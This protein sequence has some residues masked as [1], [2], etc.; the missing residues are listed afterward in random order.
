MYSVVPPSGT[1]TGAAERPARDLTA[2]IA[3]PTIEAGA[4][5]E[6]AVALA[7]MLVGAGHRA[8]V[9]SGG[10]RLESRLAEAGVDLVRLDMASRSPLALARN[11]ARLRDLVRRRQCDVVHAHGRAAAWSALTAARTA[12]VPFLTTWYKGFREQNALKRV[13]NGVMARGARV[14]TPSDQLAELIVARHH[15]AWERIAVI[16]A[17]IDA[18]QFD[19][20]ALTVERINA[21]RR[22]WGVKADTKV[23]LVPGRMLR[24]KG[25]HVA[26][27][28]ARRLKDMG[29]KNFLFVFAGEDQGRSRYSGELWDLVLATGTADVIR[30]GWQAADVVAAYGAATAV[31]SAAIQPEGAPRPI[32]EAMAMARPVLVSDLAAGH[33]IV[34][35]PPIVPEDRMTGWRFAA[36][37]S[38]ALAAGLVRLMSMPDAARRAIGRRAREWVLAHCAPATVERQTLAVYAAVT[39]RRP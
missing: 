32:L 8:I 10:G 24:R 1:A 17:A 21:V 25:H 9:A 31:V 39:D 30:L 28:A 35:A 33:D 38:A 14:I 27:A 23:I 15:V 4:A 12:G 6:G 16:P 36:G 11:A 37:D 13:Y 18:G 20:T 22:S 26:V 7:L 34:L 2:L 3:V 19:P 29:L 5:D